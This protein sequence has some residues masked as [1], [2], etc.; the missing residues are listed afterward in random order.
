VQ[1][2]GSRSIHCESSLV[3]QGASK[4]R[5]APLTTCDALKGVQDEYESILPERGRIQTTSV[6][7]DKLTLSYKL[8]SLYEVWKEN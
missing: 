2:N 5:W 7:M 4:R 8:G 1:K 3:A 6:S